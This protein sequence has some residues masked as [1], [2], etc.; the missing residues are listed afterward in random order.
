MFELPRTNPVTRT[1]ILFNVVLHFYITSSLQNSIS[2]TIHP[3]HLSLH[4]SNRRRSSHTNTRRRLH[5]RLLLTRTNRRIRLPRLRGRQPYILLRPHQHGDHSPRLE[6]KHA[7]T[8]HPQ[9]GRNL[10]RVARNRNIRIV[11]MSE[12]IVQDDFGTD[13]LI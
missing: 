1:V 10:P 9:K 6:T 5:R 3:P 13:I 2:S 4:R 11:V 12:D 8:Q 7:M